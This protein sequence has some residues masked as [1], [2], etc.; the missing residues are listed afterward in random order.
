MNAEEEQRSKGGKI[1]NHA[2][3]RM[4]GC[5]NLQEFCTFLTFE[6]PQRLKSGLPSDRHPDR[7]GCA[8]VLGAVKV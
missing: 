2:N 7:I 8:V 3:E 6:Q 4:G 5:Q 1:C